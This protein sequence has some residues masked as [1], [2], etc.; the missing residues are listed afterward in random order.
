MRRLVKTV[1]FSLILLFLVA[2]I[3]AAI[4]YEIIK[5]ETVVDVTEQGLYDIKEEFL[6][7]FKEPAHG[8][9]R[10]IPTRYNLS[11]GMGQLEVKISKIKVNATSRINYQYNDM[12]IQIGD[13]DRYVTGEQV[14]KISYRYDIGRQVIEN[15]EVGFYFNLLGDDWETPINQ[16]SFRINLPKEVSPKAVTFFRGEKENEGVDWTLNEERRSI[17][18]FAHNLKKGEGV[19]VKI[20]L[21]PSY[22]KSRIDWQTVLR[23]PALVISFIL[24][25]LAFFQWMKV[26]R[27]DDLIVVPQFEPPEGTTPLDVGYIIDKSVDP[28]DVTAMIFYW[29]DRGNLT[30]VENKK[31]LSLIKGREL[32]TSNEAE[33]VLYDGLFALGKGPVV[34]IKDLEGNFSKIF[35]K[36]KNKVE[37]RYRNKNALVDEKSRKAAALITA[38]TL[39]SSCMYAL[40]LTANNL[41]VFSVILFFIAGLSATVFLVLMNLIDRLWYK[42]APFKKTVLFV[43]LLVSVIISLSLLLVASF[44]FVDGI[45]QGVFAAVLAAFTNFVL[46]LFATITTRRS[47]Y[48]QEKLEKVLGLRDFILKVELDQIKRMSAENPSFYYKLISFAIVL[49]LE[50]KWSKKFESITLQKPNWYQTESATWNA[51]VLSSLF[52]RTNSSIVSVSG[53]SSKGGHSVSFSGASFGGGGFGGGGGGAW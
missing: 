8:F 2:P 28:Q 3:F 20:D 21:E 50:K 18:G 38:S 47:S 51:L 53:L 11:D 23:F 12:V 27:D 14:Y 46:A 33:R 42:S 43:V 17:E 37:N 31:E 52:S 4:N 35:Q 44:V 41:D 5:A 36:V 45:Y 9:Y 19:T 39:I 13:A 25:G 26:G 29:A 40:L 48:G 49:G 1:C 15:N 34:R 10:I 22:F 16:F 30:I 6:L 24:M 32:T 7:N